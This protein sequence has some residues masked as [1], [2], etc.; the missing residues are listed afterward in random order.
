[1]IISG[2]QEG[3]TILTTGLM[4]VKQDSPVKLTKVD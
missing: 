3:D 4:S 1:M 2:L